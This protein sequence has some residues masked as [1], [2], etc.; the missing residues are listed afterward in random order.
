[1]TFGGVGFAMTSLLSPS[2]EQNMFLHQ[3]LV[4]TERG[5][6]IYSMK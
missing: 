1:M 5:N 6:F 4:E 3:M 2:M